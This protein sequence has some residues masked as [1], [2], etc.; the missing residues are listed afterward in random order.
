M[1]RQAQHL[2]DVEQKVIRPEIHLPCDLVEIEPF[3]K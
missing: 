3:N 1:R 2:G